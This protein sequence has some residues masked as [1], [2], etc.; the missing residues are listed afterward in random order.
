MATQY[1]IIGIEAA[2]GDAPRA[3][4]QLNGDLLVP[5][6]GRAAL[7]QALLNAEDA[8][9]DAH[10][11]ERAAIADARKLLGIPR[12]DKV[13]RAFERNLLKVRPI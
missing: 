10:P 8:L 4:E 12:E 1:L 9:G 11:Q 3:V 5:A 6:R 7:A 13:R 2:P